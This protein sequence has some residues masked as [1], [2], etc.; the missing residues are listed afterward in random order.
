VTVQHGVR[1]TTGQTR[2]RFLRAGRGEKMKIVFAGPEPAQGRQGRMRAREKDS[3]RQL[4]T[5]VVFALGERAGLQFLCCWL[6]RRASIGQDRHSNCTPFPHHFI[7]CFALLLFWLLTYSRLKLLAPR[8]S[9]SITQ[10]LL[11]P[12]DLDLQTTRW[13]YKVHAN[14]R[15]NSDL[16]LFTRGGGWGGLASN[17]FSLVLVHSCSS[18]SCQLRAAE[19]YLPAAGSET[20][21]PSGRQTMGLGP[22]A[23]VRCM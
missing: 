8:N 23:Y 13:T 22:F 2:L 5:G 4:R 18:D 16:S 6:A 19:G 1:K 10:L 11:S 7:L 21:R 3:S 9:G 12:K 15:L 14:I 20:A 17:G